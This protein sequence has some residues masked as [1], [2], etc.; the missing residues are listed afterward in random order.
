MSTLTQFFSGA[1]VKPPTGVDLR[2]GINGLGYEKTGANEITIK[3]GSC[4]DKTDSVNLV[5]AADQAVAIPATANAIIHLFLANDGVVHA[6]DDA[7]GANVIAGGVTHIRWMGF[8][9]TDGT[10][11]VRQCHLSARDDSLSFGSGINLGTKTK[12]TDVDISPYVYTPRVY[13][14]SGSGSPVGT[15]G[16]LYTIGSVKDNGLKIW[17]VGAGSAS[18]A[19]YA[20]NVPFIGNSIYLSPV[21]DAKIFLILAVTIDR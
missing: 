19:W 21:G 9:P 6:D 13:E 18:R 17:E 8:A 14:Y 7:A 11:A 3:A 1:G 12:G 10:G 20:H 4:R 15:T 5:L 2:G 16:N